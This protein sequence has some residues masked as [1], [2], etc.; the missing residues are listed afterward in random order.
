MSLLD[1]IDTSGNV[2]ELTSWATRNASLANDLVSIVDASRRMPLYDLSVPYAAPGESDEQSPLEV[3]YDYDRVNIS[4]FERECSPGLQR[5][6]CLLP[7][8][9]PGLSA[10]E[11]GTALVDAPWTATWCGVP[12]LFVKDESRNP[13]WSHKDRLNICTVSAAAALGATGVAISSTGNHGASAA[14][15]AARAGIPCVVLTDDGATAAYRQLITAYGAAVVAMPREARWPMLE[16]LCAQPGWHLIG[17]TARMHTGHPFGPEGYK[18]IAY[19]LYQQLGNQ[20]PAAIAVPT[21]YGELL[22]GICK[23]FRELKRL[24]LIGRMP[25]MISAEPS[26]CGPVARAMARKLNY[27]SI[28]LGNTVARAI[29]AGSNGYRPIQALRESGGF[30]CLVE[31]GEMQDAQRQLRRDGLWAETASCAGLAA[32]RQLIRNNV[33][34]DGPVVAVATSTGLKEVDGDSYAVPTLQAP[35]WD[36]LSGLLKSRYGLNF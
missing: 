20:A 16:R 19:E 6:Q 25:A 24:G 26:T 23:G 2:S 11:G 12:E 35:T 34:F 28:P 8:L 22:F 32:V 31:D 3:D 21:G 13:T 30:P 27:V 17:N 5:W 9:M 1:G 36:D 18:T 4:I 7:P 15:Y 33:Q 14:A 29:A 10:G